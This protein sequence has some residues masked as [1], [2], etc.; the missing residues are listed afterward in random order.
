M[1]AGD[2]RKVCR[3]CLGGM[4]ISDFCAQNGPGQT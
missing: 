3:P 2:A 1:E 4:E